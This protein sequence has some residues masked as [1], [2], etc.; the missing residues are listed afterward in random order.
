MVGPTPRSSPFSDEPWRLQT[1]P[2][3]YNNLDVSSTVTIV[4]N[5]RQTTT[6]CQPSQLVGHTPGYQMLVILCDMIDM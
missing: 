4:L 5:T 1:L 3:R 2:Y 6:N